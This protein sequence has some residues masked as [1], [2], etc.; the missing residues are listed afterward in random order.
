MHDSRPLFLVFDSRPLVLVIDS[1]YIYIYYLHKS[2]LDLPKIPL[3]ILW[4]SS[5]LRQYFELFVMPLI[6][7]WAYHGLNPAIAT[8]QWAHHYSRPTLIG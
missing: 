5:L 8:K 4:G 1:I 7:A 3:T 2:V 6:I